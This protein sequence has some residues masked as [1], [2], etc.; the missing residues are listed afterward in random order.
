M[1]SIVYTYSMNPSHTVPNILTSLRDIEIVPETQSTVECNV[2]LRKL[3][4]V[5]SYVTDLIALKLL[6]IFHN[7]TE[8][9]SE[10]RVSVGVTEK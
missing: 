7:T 4:Y 3:A 2:N 10:G 9:L 5:V 8:V 6:N 1:V